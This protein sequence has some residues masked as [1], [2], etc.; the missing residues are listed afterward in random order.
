MLKNLAENKSQ[1][2]SLIFE[3]NEALQVYGD[4]INEI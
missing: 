4:K 1:I 3:P 2:E